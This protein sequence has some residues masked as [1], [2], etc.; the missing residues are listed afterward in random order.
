MANSGEKNSNLPRIEES[1][2]KLDEILLSL[3]QNLYNLH[4]KIEI[5]DSK[6]EFQRIIKIYK[7]NIETRE[8]ELEAEVK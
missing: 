7:N 5:I 6:P 2:T 8:S 1:I 3:K 4:Q